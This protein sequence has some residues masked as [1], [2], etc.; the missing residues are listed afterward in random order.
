MLG[1]L[2]IAQV[3]RRE[4][5]P[6]AVD[7]EPE[8][9]GAAGLPWNAYWTVLGTVVPL[10]SYL[11]SQWTWQRSSGATSSPGFQSRGSR[12]PSAATEP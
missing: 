8:S 6:R 9:G 12:N 11:V 5:E 1:H 7:G 3:E 2:L 10:S 4:V